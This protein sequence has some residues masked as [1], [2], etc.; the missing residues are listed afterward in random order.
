MR[1]GCRFFQQINIEE[2]EQSKSF[3]KGRNLEL[4]NLRNKMIC[5]R[6]YYYGKIHKIN[7]ELVIDKLSEEFFL[8]LRTVQDIV[9]SNAELLK[10]IYKQKPTVTTLKKEFYFF[11]WADKVN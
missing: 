7:F 8:S 9:A 10:E 5:Y 3:K 2:A 4:V 1:R 11:I 6:Y